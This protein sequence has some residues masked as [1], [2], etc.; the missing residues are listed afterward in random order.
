MLPITLVDPYLPKTTTIST[1]CI[2]FFIFVVGQHRNFKF[3]RQV[4]HSKSP[5][6][7]DKPFPVLLA[8]FFKNTGQKQDK[9]LENT[10]QFTG[11][12]KTYIA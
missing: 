3:G 10:G 1:L 4:D 6:M 11:H 8:G 2:A 7:D 5:R 12:I 9:N